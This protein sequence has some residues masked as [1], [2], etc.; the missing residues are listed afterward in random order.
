MKSKITKHAGEDR[1]ATKRQKDLLKDLYKQYDGC[2][3]RTAKKR[4][5]GLKSSRMAYM[6]TRRL[7]AKSRGLKI[8]LAKLHRGSLDYAE[9][10]LNPKNKKSTP[11]QIGDVIG[12]YI[13]TFPSVKWGRFRGEVLKQLQ[14]IRTRNERKVNGKESSNNH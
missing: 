5:N 12:S 8:D 1:P 6:E 4:V 7:Y 11:E 13:R 2:D 9:F 3:E 14:A 10:V